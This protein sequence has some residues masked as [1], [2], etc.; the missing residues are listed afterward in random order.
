MTDQY[1]GRFAPSPTGKLH[2]GSLYA[3]LASFVDAKAHQGKW[4]VR[5]EDIDPPRE[6]AG[7]TDA[8]INALH[9]HGLVADEPITYQ[10]NQYP[11]YQQLINQLLKQHQAYYCSCSRK[12]LIGFN[13][14]Y[15][16]KCRDNTEATSK[17][18]AIRLKVDDQ[19][20][21]FDDLLLDT[22]Q[23]AKAPEGL[24]EDFII[25]R[26]DQ[27][28]AYQLAVVADDITAHVNTVVRG[29]DL[30]SCTFKQLQLY[31]C[32]DKT[33]PQYLHLPLLFQN[34]QKL[35]KQNYAKPINDLKAGENLQ[36]ALTLLGQKT[37]P[38]L[39]QVNDI[40]NFAI[41]HWDRKRIAKTA[42]LVI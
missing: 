28:Y 4:L 8:I 9:A 40:V 29:Q 20:L 33:P 17:P 41:E 37:D 31:R 5:I 14:Y 19:K 7:A 39:K 6:E 16:G 26:K 11:R 32:L 15:N 12:E 2:L 42:K 13:G 22:Q 18:C 24:Y 10:H 35:S 21:R 38:R 25:K 1:I 30:L 34:G 36:Y 27:L 3:A 23:Q